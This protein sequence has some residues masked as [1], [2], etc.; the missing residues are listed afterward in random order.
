LPTVFS[1]CREI[2]EDKAEDAIAD[3]ADNNKDKLD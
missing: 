2:K 3:V 1:G